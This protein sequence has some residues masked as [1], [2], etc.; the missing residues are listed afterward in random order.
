VDEEA[1]I[2]VMDLARRMFDESDGDTNGDTTPI[3]HS[4]LIL[5]T[6]QSSAWCYYMPNLLET[7]RLSHAYM[8]SVSA[9]QVKSI[10]SS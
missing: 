4:S 3:P 2:L 1:S 5:T 7:C 6:Q 10:K 8:N 9:I